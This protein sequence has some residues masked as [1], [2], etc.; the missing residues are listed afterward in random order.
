MIAV[1]NGFCVN[2]YGSYNRR[3]HYIFVIVIFIFS[4]MFVFLYEK[5]I[6]ENKLESIGR[7][8]RFM[9][10]DLWDFNTVSLNS[11][12]KM[13]M[14]HEDLVSILVRDHTN[15]S[16]VNLKNKS[17]IEKS[18]FLTRKVFLRVGLFKDGEYIGD[19]V[20][21]WRNTSLRLHTVVLLVIIC[22]IIFVF[23]HLKMKENELK[24]EKQIIQTFK[25]AEL[26]QTIA[27][28]VHELTNPLTSILGTIMMMRKRGVF[29]INDVDRIDRAAT[30][31]KKII[32]QMRTSSRMESAENWKK[33]DIVK[34]IQNSLILH[35]KQLSVEDIDFTLEM[36]EGTPFIWGNDTQ[37]ESVFSNLLQNGRDAFSEINDGRK[38]FISIKIFTD[39]PN[40]V[41]IKY[42]DNAGGMSED[43]QR[44]IFEPF[45][46][47]KEI[48][49]GTGLGM[50]VTYKIIANHNGK[51]EVESAVG[52]GTIFHITFKT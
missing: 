42:E 39:G 26:G 13:I 2:N 3:N 34:V 10:K 6:Y 52:K 48:K 33:L 36:E 5:N 28:I 30:R 40:K 11:H 25:L 46:T 8:A 47:T 16:I 4:S 43:V 29:L 31:M 35:E 44:R 38:R 23:I 14:E 9:E 50:S 21:I 32:E 45:F 37:L 1:V 17:T 15:E 27:G 22:L 18:F 41:N 12:S 49:K 7:Y 20:V 19:L 51:M 24:M